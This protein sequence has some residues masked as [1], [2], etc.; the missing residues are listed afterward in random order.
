MI[1]DGRGRIV[2]LYR[3]DRVLK[4]ATGSGDLPDPVFARIRQRLLA[5]T[6][7]GMGSRPIGLVLGAAVYVG[8]YLWIRSYRT[9]SASR[10]TAWAMLGWAALFLLSAW[11]YRYRVP[12]A[13]REVMTEALLAKGRCASCGYDLNGATPDAHGRAACPEC[14]A[15]WRLTGHA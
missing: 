14:G 3:I 5:Q 4:Q 1:R 10:V 13:R 7:A 15:A 12:R 6:R 11:M 9:V 8:L 2:P